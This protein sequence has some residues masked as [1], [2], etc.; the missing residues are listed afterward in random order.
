[1]LFLLFSHFSRIL[2]YV[3]SWIV[4]HEAPLS[5]EFPR[6]QYWS[7]L[8]LGIKLTSPVW[9]ADSFTTEPPANPHLTDQETD[10]HKSDLP[11]W[12]V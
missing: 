10:C 4:T 3:I 8:L 1:M 6:Q 7:G 11:E 9:Q 2:L 5:M 12:P